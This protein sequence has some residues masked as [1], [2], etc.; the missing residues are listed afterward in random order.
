MIKG[1]NKWD[2]TQREYMW[3]QFCDLT[4]PYKEW[5]HPL[6]QHGKTGNIT[7]TK[8]RVR[9]ALKEV[10]MRMKMRFPENA[11]KYT[12]GSIGNQIAYVIG[13]Q[14]KS[15]FEE[16]SVSFFRSFIRNLLAAHSVGFI[17]EVDLFYKHPNLIR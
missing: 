9:D 3:Q 15:Y 6:L 4:G 12:L 14:H 2:K 8:W 1:H 10:L 11:H 7:P 16:K 13:K 5:E 17:D